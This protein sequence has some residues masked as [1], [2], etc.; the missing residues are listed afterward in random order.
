MQLTKIDPLWGKECEAVQLQALPDADNLDRLVKLQDALQQESELKLRRIPRQSLHCTVLTLLHPGHHFD[1]SKF[2]IWNEQAESWNTSLFEQAAMTPGFK[3]SFDQLTSSEM[4]IFVTAPE[5]P[6]LRRMRQ[7]VSHAIQYRGRHPKPPD[8][9]HITLFRYDQVGPIPSK[10]GLAWQGL[11]FTMEVKKLRLIK[12]TVYPT[13]QHQAVS[14]LPLT[15][16]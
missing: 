6:V 11:P 12:E 16:G 13:L 15:G 8:I 5:P 10:A 14:E 7:D 9:V 4:A 3:L 2:D 1:R